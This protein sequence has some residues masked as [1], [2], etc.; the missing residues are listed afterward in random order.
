[1]KNTEG[2]RKVGDFG[3]LGGRHLVWERRKDK[4]TRVKVWGG[5]WPETSQCF[6]LPLSLSVSFSL[7]PGF[8]VPP[9][10]RWQ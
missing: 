10:T 9:P 2:V 3:V 4:V 7:L 8:P 5:S 1:M 6:L